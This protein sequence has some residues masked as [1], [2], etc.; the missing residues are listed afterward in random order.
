M[1]KVKVSVHP[2]C[3]VLDYTHFSVLFSKQR[4]L[5]V[6]CAVNI[7]GKNFVQIN[8]SRDVWKKD[9][10]V[11]N[12]QVTE[13]FYSITNQEFHKGHIVRRLDPCWGNKAEAKQA[14]ED[15]FHYTNACPQHRKFNPQIWL[16]LER[17][18]LEKGAV[19]A[20]QKIAVF[21]GPVLHKGDKPFIKKADEELIFIPSHFWKVVV[22]QKTDGKLYAVGFM[23]SQKGLIERLVDQQYKKPR[24]RA[25]AADTYYEDLKFKNNAVY[26]VSIS[27]IEKLAGISFAKTGINFPAVKNNS[28]ELTVKKDYS[29][30]V[31]GGRFRSAAGESN[32]EIAGMNLG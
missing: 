17:S 11:L 28:M 21:S 19:H 12:D 26:Q 9:T 22:W 8:R 24:T 31:R 25:I 13:S 14:E 23:Q 1:P 29:N 7:D 5:P 2:D 3:T 20:E 18:I 27:L 4:K 6:C 16:E 10:A 15:T 32:I 30:A